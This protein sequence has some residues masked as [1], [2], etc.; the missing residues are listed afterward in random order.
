MDDVSHGFAVPAHSCDTVHPINHELVTSLVTFEEFSA[1]YELLTS[2]RIVVVTP[3]DGQGLP[4]P[5]FGPGYEIYCDRGSKMEKRFILP[6]RISGCNGSWTNSDDVTWV[7]ATIYVMGAISV[8]FVG[9]WVGNLPERHRVYKGSVYSPHGRYNF[10]FSQRTD[11]PPSLHEVESQIN[12][13]NGEATGSDDLDAVPVSDVGDRLRATSGIDS[14]LS[15]TSSVSSKTTKS[16]KSV[17]CR[18]WC[19]GTCT[20]ERCRFNHRPEAK[21]KGKL[22]L[23]IPSSP[24]TTEELTSSSG[25]P[26]SAS[27]GSSSVSTPKP[28]TTAPP[29]KKFVNVND[30]KYMVLGNVPV[31]IQ[32]PQ[33]P[34]LLYFVL[35][36]VFLV[37]PF[38]ASIFAN[39]VVYVGYH[40]VVI[41][42][43]LISALSNL[44]VRSLWPMRK[45]QNP[46]EDVHLQ[47]AAYPRYVA[48][49]WPFSKEV[50]QDPRD[51]LSRRGL[52]YDSEV[53][54]HK[55]LVDFLIKRYRR[56]N[57]EA[58]LPNSWYKSIEDY[59]EVLDMEIINNSVRRAH[60]VLYSYHMQDVANGLYSGRAAVPVGR[61]N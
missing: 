47:H 33:T 29:P 1:V 27:G 9:Y 6:S 20:R 3:L 46:V 4:H 49:W 7:D 54:C 12:G 42:W 56:S 40:L 30:L 15:Q 48:A 41:L 14:A 39:L 5:D 34:V 13:S 18:H 31:V 37:V 58:H 52:T 22:S 36:I 25:S 17:D 24:S 28:P 44:L 51:F 38:P 61:P 11:R 59:V 19:T 8:L 32:Q 57:I 23:K 10:Y 50:V 2:Q 26:P 53:V 55:E 45:G 60:Q 16:T 35:T 43:K 21:F